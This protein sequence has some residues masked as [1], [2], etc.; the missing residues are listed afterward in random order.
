MPLGR[1]AWLQGG[2]HIQLGAHTIPNLV[3]IRASP[4]LLPSSL[5]YLHGADDLNKL[6]LYAHGFP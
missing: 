2:D 5:R 4:M 1:L 3:I 6:R